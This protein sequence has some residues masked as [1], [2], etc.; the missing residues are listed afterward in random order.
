MMDVVANV[1]RKKPGTNILDYFISAS[2]HMLHRFGIVSMCIGTY[3]PVNPPALDMS[4]F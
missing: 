3:I 2:S 4:E 1:D